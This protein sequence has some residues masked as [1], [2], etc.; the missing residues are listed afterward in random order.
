MPWMIWSEGKRISRF[1]ALDAPPATRINKRE[2][3]MRVSKNLEELFRHDDLNRAA[4]RQWLSARNNRERS[5]GFG[6]LKSIPLRCCCRFC[7]VPASDL[8][9]LHLDWKRFPGPL[10]RVRAP[11]Q[12]RGALA[13]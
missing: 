4:L 13:D 11:L 9:K 7:S 6:S 3:M 10:F 2:Q 5:T 8:R 12:G 1:V